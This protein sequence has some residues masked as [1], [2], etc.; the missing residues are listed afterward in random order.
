MTI[1][2]VSG[3]ND[4][5]RMGVTLDD[6]GK[7]G[8]LMDGNC[9][10]HHRLDLGDRP[11]AAFTLFGKGVRQR[12]VE[13]KPPPTLI[14]N[15]IAD[16]DTHRGALERCGELCSQMRAPVI[17]HPRNVL[18]T[19]RDQVACT[20]QGIPGVHMPQ[21]QRF[22]PRAPDE[23]FAFADEAGFAVPFIV[24]VAGLH[25]GVSML[26]VGSRDDYASLHAL[27]FDGRD[28]YLTEFVDYR[29]GDGNYRKTRFAVVDGVPLIRHHLIDRDWKVHAASLEYMDRYRALADEQ[30]SLLAD[31]DRTLKPQLAA[32]VSE[33]AH[34]LGL[35]YFGIDCHLDAEG[36][37]LV[38]E[39]NA[40]MNI[41]YNSRREYDACLAVIKRHLLRLIDARAAGTDQAARG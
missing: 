18:A 19:T 34:R 35:D 16:A 7:L 23:V 15:Q 5:S 20:L 24:R 17:N 14:F 36:G 38:F 1:L 27:P 37:M 25:G 29:S 41:L 4:L 3:I 26:R 11:V 10:V 28:F 32:R 6:N 13:F 8:F 40:N 2:F 21:T 12:A 31:F 39:A 9:S 33:I 22:Q 30:N